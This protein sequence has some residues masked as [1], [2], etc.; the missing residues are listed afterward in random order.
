[1][2][3]IKML[4]VAILA[5]ACNSL[6][7]QTQVP[8]NST[9]PIFYKDGKVGIGTPSINNTLQV[10]A[11]PTNGISSSGNAFAVGVSDTDRMLFGVNDSR[12][13]WI[14][15]RLANLLLCPHAGNV[16]IGTTNPQEKLEVKGSLYLGKNDPYIYWNSN[17]LNL[18][19][20]YNCIPV[21]AIRGSQNYASRL[22]MYAAGD[23]EQTV[24]IHTGSSSYFNGGNVGIGTTTPNYKLD[25]VG[26]IRAS[27]LKVDMQGADFV[28][29]DDY[30]LRSL[31]EV[32]DFISTNKHLPDVA[33]AK[34][35]QENG[36]NQ[37]EMNQLLLRKIE[38]LTLYVIELKKENEEMK[39]QIKNIHE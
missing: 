30:Q 34:E 36:V 14:Q 2:T 8:E 15:P 20:K 39:S 35:M 11:P 24:L 33:P 18:K 22:D 13:G 29:E 10:Y 25:V 7:A 32:E 37:S 3:K 38:E 19:S 6:F 1:M 28:F 27:E 4:L 23:T 17:H 26:T 21:V 5:I 12:N 9:S 31:N 16:G